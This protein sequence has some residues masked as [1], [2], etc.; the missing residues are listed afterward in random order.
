[1]YVTELVRLL[2]AGFESSFG[3]G[4]FCLMF[5]RAAFYPLPPHDKR[6]EFHVR[7]HELTHFVF[8]QIELEFD[9]FK[10]RFI[11]PCHLDDSVQ[12]SFRKFSHISSNKEVV[13]EV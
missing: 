6:R 11:F 5:G 9:G 3:E 4:P 2:I 7:S 8:L 13:D 10:R 1:M 12:F